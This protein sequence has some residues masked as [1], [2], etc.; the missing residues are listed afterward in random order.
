M[1]GSGQNPPNRPPTDLLKVSA[2]S[3]LTS[4]STLQMLNQI[5]V[6]RK[7]EPPVTT[8]TISAAP[9]RTLW[10]DIR[11]A[12]AMSNTPLQTLDKVT[13]AITES[14]VR[15]ARSLLHPA[16]NQ[17]LTDNIADAAGYMAHLFEIGTSGDTGNRARIHQKVHDRVD[18]YGKP[19]EHGEFEITMA[20]GWHPKGPIKYNGKMTTLTEPIK[21]PLAVFLRNQNGDIEILDPSWKVSG[22]T[23]TADAIAKSAAALSR[24][25]TEAPK[26]EIDAR[27]QRTAGPYVV[28]QIAPIVASGGTWALGKTGII[29]ATVPAKVQTAATAINNG[30]TALGLASG[31]TTGVGVARDMAQ[32]AYFTPAAVKEITKTISGIFTQSTLTADNVRKLL[33]EGLH[34]FS[35]KEGPNTKQ[36]Y[37]PSLHK[38]ESPFERL[39]QMLSGRID[40]FEKKATPWEDWP[41]FQ[42]QVK[43]DEIRQE[44][45]KNDQVNKAFY[46]AVDKHLAGKPL[47]DMDI[48]VMRVGLNLSDSYRRVPLIG[49][50]FKDG[51]LTYTDAERKDTLERLND[52]LRY[53]FDA[54]RGESTPF[55]KQIK[56]EP[57]SPESYTPQNFKL[58]AQDVLRDINLREEVEREKAM[59]QARVNAAR[60]TALGMGL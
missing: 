10:G 8:G 9:P 12:I 40:A 30:M 57:Q 4:T 56:A 35:F 28:G 50:K 18:Q 1:S 46:T 44:L 54:R 22:A 33:N 53:R 55:D 20:V 51:K 17:A 14:T 41:R 24:A 42:R 34:D 49:E 23:G 19:S 60:M 11:S 5:G 7:D 2:S 26:D 3:L 29:A 13:A 47:T 37:I 43:V 48:F 6:C 27:W 59:Q 31:V 38:A 52:D 45:M 25:M 36:I 32:S 21:N 39:E 58:L 16:I 15:G